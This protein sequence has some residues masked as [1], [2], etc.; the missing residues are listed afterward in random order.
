MAHRPE[1]PSSPSLADLQ[2][3]INDYGAWLVLMGS[4][5]I[6]LGVIA[7]AHPHPATAFVKI[8]SGWLILA[9]GI[10]RIIEAAFATQL[11]EFLLQLSL[12]T[13]FTVVGGCL[14]FFPLA[15]ILTLTFGAAVILVLQGLT[16][17]AIGLRV[18]SFGLGLAF[19]SAGAATLLIGGLIWASLPSTSGWV[20]GVLLGI[21]LIGAGVTYISLAVF[22]HLWVW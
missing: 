15:G 16:K 9:M 8:I 6:V 11:H 20:I 2:R 7:I 19:L 4:I 13:L 3:T 18:R 10:S 1:I 5:A 22:A 21:N 14:A 12:G 17:I